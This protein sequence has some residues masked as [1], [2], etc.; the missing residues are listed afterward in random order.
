MSD[1]PFVSKVLKFP[2]GEPIAPE[3][4]YLVT[5]VVIGKYGTF[6]LPIRICVD[7]DISPEALTMEV[8][9]ALAKHYG[10][11]QYPTV[12]P[13]SDNGIA[14]IVQRVTHVAGYQLDIPTEY[15]LEIDPHTMVDIFATLASG[16]G[17]KC[18][19]K[20]DGSDAVKFMLAGRKDDE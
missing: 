4:C 5:N 1:K 15:H 20:S 3:G 13:V 12:K 14:T 10:W 18:I 6:Q 19:G 11:K 7:K 2:T 9:N 16:Y 17:W 8:F